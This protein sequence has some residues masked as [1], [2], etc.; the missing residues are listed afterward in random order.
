MINFPNSL[1]TNIWTDLPRSPD[2]TMYL[3]QIRPHFFAQNNIEFTIL[4]KIPWTIQTLRTDEVVNIRETW[5]K[6]RKQELRDSLR[7]ILGQDLEIL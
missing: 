7:D 6:R 5:E 4:S 3:R 2:N 1:S